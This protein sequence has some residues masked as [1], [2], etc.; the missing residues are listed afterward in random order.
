MRIFFALIILSCTFICGQEQ[1]PMGEV[2]DPIS[3]ECKNCT[4]FLPGCAVCDSPSICTS[5]ISG[6]KLVDY[7]CEPVSVCNPGFFNDESGNCVPCASVL[8]HCIFCE[9]ADQ[10]LICS[11]GYIVSNGQCKPLNGTSCDYGSYYDIDKASCV[12]CSSV[13]SYC[14]HCTNETTC[15]ACESGTILKN[16]N[17]VE[18]QSKSCPV[19]QYLDP[20]TQNCLNCSLAL[21]NCTE[22][23]DES[24]CIKCS[25]GMIL[26][27]GVCLLPEEACEPG[28]FYN[29]AT[30]ECSRCS[31][32]IPD[33][34]ICDSATECVICEEG[35]I[36]KDG[37]CQKEG[38]RLRRRLQ[39][40][41]FQLSGNALCPTSYGYYVS[42]KECRACPNACKTCRDFNGTLVC[43]QCKDDAYRD[44]LSCKTCD[45]AICHCASCL[46]SN[47]CIS[48]E[49]GYYLSGTS[50][51]L[52][53]KD[54]IV[55]CSKCSNAK[56]CL[57]CENPYKVSRKTG[58]CECAKP[59]CEICIAE[60]EGCLKCKKGYHRREDGL[61]RS[62]HITCADC[63][64]RGKNMCVSCPPNAKLVKR[65]D[66]K[67]G[68]CVCLAGYT[69]DWRKGQCSQQSIF[70][71]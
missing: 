42:G 1:C 20:D 48:C 22:C 7:S 2:F 14:E 62:C 11:E 10:C 33:C 8:P 37:K 52:P 28:T 58:K 51:C 64:G 5:C 9:N 4:E 21:A 55:G 35:M 17:C 24:T 38:Q 19:G 16:G 63:V 31:E 60:Y 50:E 6:Y 71:Q 32:A 53:C 43:L 68:Y 23:I 67:T 54:A 47:F 15:L 39:D 18:V 25:Q 66:E 70:G 13:L 49:D 36:L 41:L 59:N 26:M 27:G 40:I 29:S 46:T 56:N 69:F 57:E 12:E 34:L 30:K 45:S 44:G 3:G 61:C 65:K